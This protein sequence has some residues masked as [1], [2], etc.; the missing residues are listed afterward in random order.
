MKTKSYGVLKKTTN[1]N[2]IDKQLEELKILGYTIIEDLIDS[3][4]LKIYR[5]KLD[6]VYKKQIDEFSTKEL[7]II[8]DLQMAR[9]PFLYDDTFCNLF[10]NKTILSLIEE[11]LGKYFVLHLQNGIINMPNEI[12]HQTSWH[13]DLPYNDFTTSE[14]IAI[15]VLYCIDDFN[16]N[17]GGTNVLPSSHLFENMPSDEFIDN[18]TKQIEAN[19]GS[20]I[21]FNSMLF[22]KA[23]NNTSINIRRGVNHMFTKPFIKQQ[24]NISSSF[25]VDKLE[26]PILN[27]LIG[28]DFVIENN[29]F[30][31]RKKRINKKI[32]NN[33]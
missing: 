8:N 26:N 22:H 12:H 28:N 27:M 29:V 32:N 20:A 4:D 17:T 11:L 23:G 15:S 3:N 19:A 24:L 9:M 30:D 18:H 16:M 1:L 31:F 10:T 2:L 25:S 13:R 6:L 14:P 7:D 21:I 33:E 5:E